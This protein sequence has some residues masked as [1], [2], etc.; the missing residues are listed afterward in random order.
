MLCVENFHKLCCFEI[1]TGRISP[2]PYFFSC[3]L[4]HFTRK[5]VVS[6][7]GHYVLVELEHLSMDIPSA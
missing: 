6:C 7:F 4:E 1:P 5:F 3:D 2:P